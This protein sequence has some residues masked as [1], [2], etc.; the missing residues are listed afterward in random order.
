MHSLVGLIYMISDYRSQRE[1]LIL[2]SV[3]D[4][5]LGC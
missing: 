1:F 3:A 5:Y 2:I 4:D